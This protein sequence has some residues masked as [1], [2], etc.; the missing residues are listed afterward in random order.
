MLFWFYALREVTVP[1]EA[2]FDPTTHLT[3]KDVSIDEYSNPKWLKV[4]LKASKTDPFRK[5]VDI[6]VGR[7]Y[8]KICPVAAVLGYL[9]IRGNSPGFLFK[10]Q[11][12]RLLTKSR[13]V[14]AVREALGRAGLNPKAFAGHSFRIG[15]QNSQCLW[16][17]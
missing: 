1:S 2:A 15:A 10:Y 7:T 13:F 17:E 4:H 6:V 9:V 16:I 8:N 12:G 11:D 5:G 3:F 14:E